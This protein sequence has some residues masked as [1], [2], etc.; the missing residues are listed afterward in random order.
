MTDRSHADISDEPE[1]LRQLNPAQQERLTEVLDEYLRKMEAGEATDRSDLIAAHPDIGEALAEYLSKLDDLNRLVVGDTPTSEIA[2]KQLGDYRL[3]RELGRGGMGIVY[4]AQQLS[5]DRMV[6]VKLLPFASLL[7][8]KYIERFKNEARAAAQLEHPNIVPVY[9]IGLDDGIHYYAMRYITGQSLDQVISKTRHETDESQG[10]RSPARGDLKPRKVAPEQLTKLLQQFAEVAEALHRAHEY[11]VVHRDIKPSN[12]LLDLQG[13]LWLADFGLARFQTD[14][15]LTRTGEMIGTMR[16]MSPEQVAGRAE[17]ID[18][19]TDIYSLGATLYEALSLE[20]AIQGVEGPALLRTIELEAPVKLKKLCPGLP[21]DVQTLVEKAMTKHRDDRYATADMFAQDLRRASS[22]YPILASRLSPLVL[23]WRWAENRRNLVLAGTAVMLAAIIGLTVSVVM[24]NLARSETEVSLRNAKQNWSRA[25][26][27]VDELGSELAEELVGVPGAE[28]VRKLALKKT[29]DYYKQFAAEIKG[30]N[31]SDLQLDLAKTYNRI[32]ALSEE[33]GVTRAAIA[34][35]IEADNT[36]KQV[37]ERL[38]SNAKV[39]RL[40]AENLN[41]LGLAYGKVERFTEAK[42]AFESALEIE[43]HLSSDDEADPSGLISTGL[44]KNNFGLL[45]QNGGEIQRAEA[46]YR[47]AIETLT[48]IAER[49][50]KAQSQVGSEVQSTGNTAAQSVDPLKAIPNDTPNDMSNDQLAVR[51]LGA[52]LSNLGSIQLMQDPQLAEQTI[53]RALDYQLPMAKSSS[54][55]MRAS[56]DIVASYTNL[57]NTRLKARNWKG[58]EEAS[59]DAVAISEQLVRIAPAVELYKLDLATNLS[60]LGTSLQNQNRFQ[61][62]TEAFQRSIENLTLREDEGEMHPK[63]ASN[64]GSVHNNL[65]NVFMGQF[66]FEAARN[67]LAIA[68]ELQQKALAAA[69]NK[70]TYRENLGK[71]LANLTQLLR[72]LK[73]VNRELEVLKQRRELWKSDADRLQAVADE[74]ALLAVR[75][76]QSIDELVMTTQLCRSVGVKMDDLLKR[77]PFQMLPES[78]RNRLK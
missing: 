48:P 66:N 12:L 55:P 32:G 50:L 1:V 52:A 33:L 3:I 60:N 41:S 74:F 16:Y 24:I 34:E 54:F 13:K 37:N 23:A 69:P 38:A 29:L 77:A 5:L 22:G 18:H 53:L 7:E 15:P 76:P 6:A 36:Y 42:Q 40:M 28:G 57:A 65:A 45:L 35:Y 11:G 21:L 67:E 64:R 70:A 30:N 9:S 72:Q 49:L 47:D 17:L 43:S 78:V 25:R 20:P 2:G 59:R 68:I 26:L 58:A 27:A 75:S 56:L 4:L 44:T 51:G 14:S 8:P 39:Q 62:A 19:R 71:S 61:D 73:D 46:M 10:T 31:D 63:L